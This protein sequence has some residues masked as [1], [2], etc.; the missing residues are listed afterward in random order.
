MFVW[1]LH[2][3]S[4]TAVVDGDDAIPGMKLE[5][6]EFMQFMPESHSR[7]YTTVVLYYKIM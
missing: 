3:C 6:Q 7:N 2:D 4:R 1:E 5:Q